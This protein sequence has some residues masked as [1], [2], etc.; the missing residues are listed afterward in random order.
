M[1]LLKKLR[2]FFSIS[3]YFYL[4]GIF[5]CGTLYIVLENFLFHRN[6]CRDC[7]SLPLKDVSGVST[8]KIY[9]F[10]IYFVVCAFHLEII[11][12]ITRSNNSNN[13]IISILRIK[14]E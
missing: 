6:E 5:S 8:N 9:V 1:L 11:I 13:D 2:V 10:N 7:T 14:R 4:L 12:I 3:K